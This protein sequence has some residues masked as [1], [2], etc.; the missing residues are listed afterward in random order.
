MN[1]PPT[2]CE[3]GLCALT[4][5]SLHLLGRSSFSSSIGL[6]RYVGAEAVRQAAVLAF[7]L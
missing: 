3:I 2:N 5:I 4:G 6:R 1:V 7:K